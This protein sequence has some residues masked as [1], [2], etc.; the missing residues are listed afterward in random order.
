[1]SEVRRGWPRRVMA[2]SSGVTALSLVRSLLRMKFQFGGAPFSNVSCCLVAFLPLG[3]D[4]IAVTG[5]S[6]TPYRLSYARKSGSVWLPCS[7]ETETGSWRTWRF[8]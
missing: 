5:P 8:G 4:S 2:C 3:F 6:R 1:V 7:V